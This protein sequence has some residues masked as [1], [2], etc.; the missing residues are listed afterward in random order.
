MPGNLALVVAA[1]RGQ[2]LRASTPKQYLP[3]AGA[4][5]LRH[6]LAAFV[7]HPEIDAVAA[8]IA[9][10]DRALY[11]SATAGLALLPPISGGATRQE[12]V[13]NGLEALAAQNPERILIHDAARPFIDAGTISRVLEALDRSPAAIAAVPVADTLKRGE[14]ERIAATVERRDLWRAQTPQGFHYRAILD[15]HR[16]AASL[17]DELTDDAMVAERAGMSVTLVMGSEDN[18]KV[19][20]ADDMKRAERFAASAGEI[21]TGLGFDAHRF[22]HGNRIW[23]C[24]IEIPFEKSLSGHS[25]ADVGLHAATDALLGAIGAGDIGVHFPP[26]DPKWRGAASHQFL[27]HAA[28]RIAALGGAIVNLD[29]TLICEQPRIGPHREAMVARVAEILGLPA[30][31]VSVKATTTEGMGFTGRGDGIA[32]QAVA[33]VRLPLAR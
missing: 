11:D 13:R 8:V 27:R 16:A 14:G 3:L 28:D 7:S 5:L 17:G 15:A 26:S 10:D 22:S 2:R 21:R 19:T 1:G 31:R 30:S 24:G 4:P 29:I 32:A 18:F 20:T 25:D 9:A 33:A 12:S 6:S 23:L